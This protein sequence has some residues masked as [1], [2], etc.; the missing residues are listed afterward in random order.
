MPKGKNTLTLNHETMLGVMDLWLEAEFK[1]P[2]ECT[3]IKWDSQAEVF[4]IEFGSK[5]HAGVK[6]VGDT[7]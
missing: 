6:L 7:K 2:V 3:E 4:V 5:T 1:N